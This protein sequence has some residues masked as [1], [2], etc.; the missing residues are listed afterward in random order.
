MNI[1]VP[2]KAVDFFRL[3]HS[4]WLLKKKNN[5]PASISLSD[6]FNLEAVTSSEKLAFIYQATQ[7]HIP[8]RV[9]I[10]YNKDE[11]AG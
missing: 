7:H 4:H 5:I 6:T 1:R 11:W 10:H 9:I 2:S 3:L 8:A